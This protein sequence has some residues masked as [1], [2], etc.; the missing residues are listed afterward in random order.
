MRSERGSVLLL[1]PAAV[2]VLLVLAAITVDFSIAFLGEREL[3]NAADAAANDAASTI[4]VTWYRA[5]GEVIVDCERAA[6]V[7]VSS[8]EARAPD[9]LQRGDVRLDECA[10]DR[11][12]VEASGTVRLIFSRALPGAR[13]HAGVAAGAT[14]KAVRG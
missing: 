5:T 8:F 12:R 11:V 2:L 1:F 10:G 4:D 7:V 6:E 3:A 14:A 13:D 9:W